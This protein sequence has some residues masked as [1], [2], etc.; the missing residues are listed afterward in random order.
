MKDTIKEELESYI[1]DCKKDYDEISH[2]N[3]FNEDYYIIGYHKAKKWLEE[4]NIDVFEGIQLCRSYEIEHFGQSK[5]IF[6]NYETLVNNI[7]F[8]YG[9]ELCI[10][11]NIPL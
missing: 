5:T 8:W 11:K 10:D 4:H 3:M 7:V 1:Q 6:D 9:Q 2:Q